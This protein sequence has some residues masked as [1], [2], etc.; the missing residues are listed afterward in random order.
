MNINIYIFSVNLIDLKP[1]SFWQ[2]K[3]FGKT[4]SIQ[5]LRKVETKK[6]FE[7]GSG[8]LPPGGFGGRS[9]LRGFGGLRP[10]SLLYFYKSIVEV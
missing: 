2:N 5:L 10:L 1:Q 8:G 7:G 4:F 3:G 6:N 9:P